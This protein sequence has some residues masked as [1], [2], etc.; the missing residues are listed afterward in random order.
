MALK[1]GDSFGRY[2]IEGLLGEGGMGQVFR[3]FDPLL[4]RRVA[5]KLLRESTTHS[6]GDPSE[7]SAQIL[8]EARAAAQLHH[9]NAT[10]I[11]DVGEVDG[12]PYLTMELIAGRSLHAIVGDGS[13]TIETRVN[14]LTDVARALTAAHERGIVHRDV[15]LENI[16]IRND[17]VVKVLDFGIARRD[18]T[19]VNPMASTVPNAPTLASTLGGIAGTPLYMSPEQL[20]GQTVDARTDQFS[21]GVVAYTLLTDRSPWG[22]PSN[23]VQL[24]TAILHGLPHP[25]SARKAGIPEALDAVV[26]RSLAQT[27]EDR[28][29]T[30]ADLVRALVAS[31]SAV[32]TDSARGSSRTPPSQTAL[33]PVNTGSGTHTTSPTPTSPSRTITNLRRFSKAFATGIVGVAIIVATILVK[34]RQQQLDATSGSA[35]AAPSPTTITALPPPASTSAKALAAHAE[36]MQGI[37][38]ANFDVALL[39]FQR[40]V[41]EDPGLAA[42]WMRVAMAGYGQLPLS[43]V[44]EAFQEA[45]ERRSSLSDRDRVFLDTFDPFISREPADLAEAE[46]RLTL[47]VERWPLD[48][49]LVEALAYVQLK[50]GNFGEVLTTADRA[51][52]IDPDFADPWSLKGHALA[53]LGRFP[54]AIVALEQCVERF[55]AASDCLKIQ[56]DILNAQG[57]CPRM[58]AVARIWLAKQPS[59]ASA[60]GAVAASLVAAGKP[61]ETVMTVLQQKWARTEVPKRPAVELADR[62]P[63]DVL[64]GDFVTAEKEARKLDETVA[65]DANEAAHLTPAIFLAQILVETGKTREAGHFA[66]AFLLRREAWIADAGSDVALD[67]TPVMLRVQSRAGLMSPQDFAAQRAAFLERW[68]PS[69]PGFLRGS[70]WLAGYARSA[71]TSAQAQEALAAMPEYAPIPPFVPYMLADAELG[72]VHLLTGDRQRAT[73]ELRQATKS[74]GAYED[75]FGHTR[76]FDYLGSA[77]EASGDTAGACEAFSVVLKRWGQPGTRSVTA[78]HARDRVRALHCAEALR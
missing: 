31:S 48:A 51:I 29:P 16:M 57:S 47:A 10:T 78:D 33:P 6:S 60:L 5:I 45:M 44:R 65:T 40:C 54:E 41:R 35:S 22:E 1:P 43:E 18:R 73:A 32:P 20:R 26:L 56:V 24:V 69:L 19:E 63:L 70:L 2:L 13:I 27:P 50:R 71:E 12:I 62:L 23:M 14:W 52:A 53:R 36:G 21:W 76:A 74:C 39:A 61:R 34:D 67:P 11:F 4:E 42:G 59:S 75:P 17:G 28:F 58:G 3:A 25:P 7:G 68:R 55:P 77:L 38:D 72:R 8:R 46:R 30:M 9:P 64:A 66:S 49:E 37:R 15:K